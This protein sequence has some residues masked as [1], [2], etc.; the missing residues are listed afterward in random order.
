MS[1]VMVTETGEQ[2]G[3]INTLANSVSAADAFKNM[4]PEWKS[5][6]E[7]M[8]KDDSRMVKARYINHRGMNERLD[9]PY[10]RYA[11]EPIRMY[12]LIPGY[13]YELPM[14]FIKEINEP[15]HQ[16]MKRSGLLNKDGQALPSDKKGDSVHELVPVSF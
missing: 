5:K 16:P 11:G 6:A 7:K 8:K 4:D 1:V 3:L 9:K 10:C 15:L 12:H 2:H 13:T 14:G